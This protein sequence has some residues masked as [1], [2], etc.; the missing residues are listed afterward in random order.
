M[1]YRCISK[2]LYKLQSN[3]F[4]QNAQSVSQATGFFQFQA[5]LQAEEIHFVEAFSLAETGCI[6]LATAPPS[7]PEHFLELRFQRW[8]SE[9]TSYDLPLPVEQHSMGNGTNSVELRGGILPAF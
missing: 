8:P 6:L 3:H 5:I 1:L 7:F 4:R 9:V 2:V